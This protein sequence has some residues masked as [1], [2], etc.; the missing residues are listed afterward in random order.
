VSEIFLIAIVALSISTTRQQPELKFFF[1][2]TTS[3]N[4]S[5]PAC[6]LG[7]PQ[8]WPWIFSA[9]VEFGIRPAHSF[10]YARRASRGWIGWVEGRLS[11]DCSQLSDEATPLQRR[12]R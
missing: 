5:S 10:F 11:L 9:S 12:R 7:S 8:L 4:L 2:F 1:Q 3:S 6:S